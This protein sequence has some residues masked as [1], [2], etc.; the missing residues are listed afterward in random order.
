MMLHVDLVRLSS[1]P[2]KT[3]GNSFI[4]FYYLL[5]WNKVVNYCE[6]VLVFY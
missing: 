2:G 6:T 3:H 1:E 5:F 4:K